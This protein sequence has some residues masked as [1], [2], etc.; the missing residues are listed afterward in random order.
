[1]TANTLN[2]FP[3]YAVTRLAAGQDAD[4]VTI[5]T[6]PIAMG[7]ELVKKYVAGVGVPIIVGQTNAALCAVRGDYGTGKTHLLNDVASQ[8]EAAFNSSASPSILRAT[9]IETDPLSWFRI[10]VGQQLDRLPLYETVLR[11]YGYAGKTVAGNT[12]MTRA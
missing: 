1:M 5:I 8:L 7:R 6:P 11:L 12:G 3:D 4:A 9:C 10:K 2:P